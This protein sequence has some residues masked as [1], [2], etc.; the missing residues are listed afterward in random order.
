M[1]TIHNEIQRLI[2]QY[3]VVLFSKTFCPYCR[4]AKTLLAKYSLDEEKVY[5]LIE[6]DKVSDGEKYQ[7]ELEKLTGDRT[8]PRIFIGANCI[9]DEDDLDQL[10]KKG[11]LK[12]LL[13][14]VKAIDE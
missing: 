6:L 14:Q 1:P 5:H 11:N 3:P 12:D 7:D 8:V 9:G 10:E 13:K 2:R 4:T